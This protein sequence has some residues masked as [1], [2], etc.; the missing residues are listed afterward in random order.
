MVESKDYFIVHSPRQSGKTTCLHALTSHINSSGTC[1]A[2]TCLIG[3]MST[4]KTAEI[5]ADR[6]V[7]AFDVELDRSEVPALRELAFKQS[8]DLAKAGEYK[9]GLL[10]KNVT[11]ALDKE[12]VVFFDEAD[13]L[14][15]DTL[16]LFL[17]QL[18]DGYIQREC[19]GKLIFPRSIALVG[20]RDLRDYIVSDNPSEK[21]PAHLARPFNIK[22][23]SFVLPNFTKK[24]IRALYLQHTKATKQKFSNDAFERAWYWSEGQPWLVNALA[25]VI[26]Q[27]RRDTGIKRVIVGSDF[28]K[29][30]Q[31]I[32][33][34]KETHLDSLT[35]TL[36]R[37][38]RV[39]RVVESVITASPRTTVPI[40]I[41]DLSYCINLGILK[42]GKQ[43]LFD[44]SPANPLYSEVLIRTLT[45]PIE[46]EIPSEFSG[47]WTHG[48]TLDMKGLLLAFREFWLKNFEMMKKSYENFFDEAYSTLSAPSVGESIL[49]LLGLNPE[50][51]TKIAKV[52]ADNAQRSYQALLDEAVAHLVLQA[53]MLRALNGGADYVAREYALGTLK[54][55]LLI[56]FRGEDYP[57]EVKMRGSKTIK[58]S[59]E[60]LTG[61]MDRTVCSEGWLIIL[62]GNPVKPLSKGTAPL[63]TVSSKGKKIH[64]LR[65]WGHMQ[66]QR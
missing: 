21:L 8:L 41:D 60:Q 11:T 57:L 28:D 63:M 23:R 33:M 15:G 13:S 35:E 37:E 31:V 45:S 53:F 29:A 64:I 34:R 32:I 52:L 17:Q 59:L 5:A 22:R 9:I 10:L 25:D 3:G 58:K 36:R 43:G 30:A 46:G 39:L 19:N 50:T 27:D 65:C 62:D 38:P 56:K 1:Y 26:I 42:E 40:H 44:A 61:Y 24:D 66:R 4:A 14:H 18:R 20:M 55:D 49:S 47:M 51:A 2:L 7:R 12:L 54:V 16:I 48:D 6:F